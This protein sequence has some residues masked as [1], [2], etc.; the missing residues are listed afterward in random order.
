M[1]RLFIKTDV[2]A[3]PP[4]STSSNAN[5]TPSTFVATRLSR[6]VFPASETATEAASKE[7]RENAKNRAFL[8]E[9]VQQNQEAA[10]QRK[11]SR[12][13]SSAAVDRND[14]TT[15]RQKSKDGK[16]R[17]TR[18][19]KADLAAGEGEAS[20]TPQPGPTVV[21]VQSSRLLSNTMQDGTG[22]LSEEGHGSVNALHIANEKDSKAQSA[23]VVKTNS[24]VPD[25]SDS[26][27]STSSGKSMADSIS[28]RLRLCCFFLSIYLPFLPSFLFSIRSPP[29]PTHHSMQ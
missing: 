20:G 26:S 13:R 24:I 23:A 5:R 19:V 9:G 25:P 21:P 15:A 2:G 3:R 27:V 17:K 29:F 8:A 6:S 14:A 12:R 1:S 16:H 10:V 11:K 22:N 4:A 28:N 18:K 7:T